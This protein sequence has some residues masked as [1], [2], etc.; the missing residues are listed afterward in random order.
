MQTKNNYTMWIETSTEMDKVLGA[1]RREFLI[2][3]EKGQGSY[4][5]E[6]I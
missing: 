1:K 5:R 2:V 3:P 6:D 4:K